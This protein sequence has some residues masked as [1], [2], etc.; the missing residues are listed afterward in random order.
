MEYFLEQDNDTQ[1]NILNYA[2]E[3]IKTE[4]CYPDINKNELP[5]LIAT[6]NYKSLFNDMNKISN[7]ISNNPVFNKFKNSG[8]YIETIRILK[9][10]S[11]FNTDMVDNIFIAKDNHYIRL[12]NDNDHRE[13]KGTSLTINMN[14]IIFKSEYIVKE[15][16]DNITFYCSIGIL[17]ISLIGYY[18]YN[19]QQ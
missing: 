19:K 11:Q 16:H 13:H 12:K 1:I 18:L 7:Y 10:N 9:N 3:Y 6:I 17:G 4:L 15:R 2:S 8:D 14:K 5:D